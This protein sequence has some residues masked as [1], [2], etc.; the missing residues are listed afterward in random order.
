MAFILTIETSTKVCSV[1]L[2]EKGNL[3]SFKERFVPNSHSEL[4]NNFI[5][6]V[7]KEAK[8]QKSEI[9]A[10]CISSGPGSYTGLRIG[11]STAKGLCYALDVPLLSIDTLQGMA[12]QLANEVEENAIICPMIDARRMEVYCALYNSLGVEVEKPMAKII[13]ENSF[14]ETLSKSK[15]YI[16]GD[17]AAKCAEVIKKE[18][19][20]FKEG[21][22]PTAKSFGK[23]AFEK[24]EKESFEDV[25]YFE[26]YYLKEFHTLPSKKNLLLT[27]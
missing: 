17:G 24:Y 4:I 14:N 22:M 18:N 25:A 13:D 3:I 6:D 19:L 8:V 15:M 2:H 26:P 1:A 11:T 9:N 23:M 12:L 7:L 10:V 16:Y 20:V 5:D 27:K 21:K